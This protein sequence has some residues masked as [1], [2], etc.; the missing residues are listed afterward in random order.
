MCGVWL[1]LNCMGHHSWRT[2][3]AESVF[4]RVTD[5]KR[6]LNLFPVKFVRFFCLIIFFLFD[7]L[8]CYSG[9]VGAALAA[10]AAAA[11][12]VHFFVDHEEGSRDIREGATLS[13][14]NSHKKNKNLFNKRIFKV[15]R[16]SPR[17]T[18]RLLCSCW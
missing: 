9:Y 4:T 16:R 6:Y 17:S 15:G 11:V 5:G 12:S 1:C 13:K 3:T 7:R 8:L 10:I 14:Y 2:I 18:S